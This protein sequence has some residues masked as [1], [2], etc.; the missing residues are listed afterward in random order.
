MTSLSRHVLAVLALFTAAPGAATTIAVF[1]VTFLDTSNEPGDQ[2]ADHDRRARSMAVEVAA[3]LGR[4]TGVTTATPTDEALHAKCPT[5]DPDCQ[6]G[7]AKAA[8]A[9]VIVVTTVHKVS[10]LIMNIAVRLVDPETNRSTWAR[11]LSFRADSDDSWRRAG[12]FLGGE[13]RDALAAPAG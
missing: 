5:N 11:D 1:P 3:E 9:T 8:G 10:S 4:Q 6:L 13:I 7:L 12:R 2:T